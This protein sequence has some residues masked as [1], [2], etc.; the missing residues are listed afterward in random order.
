MTA[1]A[2]AELADPPA[3]FTTALAAEAQPGAVLVAGT[4]ITYRAWGTPGA[5]GLILVHGGAAHA[6]WWDHIAPL[7]TTGRRVLAVDLSGHGDSGRRAAYSL[8]AWAEEVMAVAAAAASPD[9]RSSSGTAWV[10]LWRCARP[11]C[12]ARS[13]RASS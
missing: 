5:S 9:R 1:A 2:L 10:V 7:L 6:R 4:E 3:W 12:S 8:D 11:D 13:S